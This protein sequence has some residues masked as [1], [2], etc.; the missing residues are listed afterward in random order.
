MPHQNADFASINLVKYHVRTLSFQSSFSSEAAVS[1]DPSD[2]LDESPYFG[3]RKYR[4][5]KTNH[6]IAQ[7]LTPLEGPPT[8]L[9]LRI[10]YDAT[11]AVPTEKVPKELQ[12]T[13]RL[14]DR[15][16]HFESSLDLDCQVEFRYARDN[17]ALKNLWFPLPTPVFPASPTAP[18]DEI[19]GIRG[20]KVR[21]DSGEEAYT[22]FLDRAADG[23]VYLVVYFAMREQL[24]QA[25][26]ERVLEQAAQV[27]TRL[28]LT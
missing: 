1:S 8:V 24:S 9:F 14:L 6:L 20:V 4:A 28:G 15:F 22:F 25:T 5:G 7:E 23:D 21:E 2:P 17:N 3:V 11:E 16:A 19:R 27:A 26:P 10:S 13:D 18:A 12:R